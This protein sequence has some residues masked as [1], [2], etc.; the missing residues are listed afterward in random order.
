M[1]KGN[2]FVN[3]L[4]VILVLV[5]VYYTY[6]GGFM[7]VEFKEAPYAGFNA[8]VVNESGYYQSDAG[9][10]K[11]K[12][13]LDLSSVEGYRHVKFFS[14]R[15]SFYGKGKYKS[16]VILDRVELLRVSESEN[17]SIVKVPEKEYL[18]SEF[19]YK[20][21]MSTLVAS[22]RINSFLDEELVRLNMTLNSTTQIHETFYRK[23]VY[24]FEID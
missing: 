3:V 23:I 11:V 10:L 12:N 21:K 6:L 9:L 14:G 1:G 2:K 18:I 24:L 13:Y 22:Y 16:G 4:L 19:P 15:D 20:N 5:G 7:A 8:V 17:Y